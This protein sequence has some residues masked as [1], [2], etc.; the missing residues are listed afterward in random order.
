MEYVL[1]K[2]SIN[3]N[4]NNNNTTTSSTRIK[5]NN[6]SVNL[7]SCKYLFKMYYKRERV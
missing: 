2:N 5:I 4:N 1:L 7:S 6:K 3:P